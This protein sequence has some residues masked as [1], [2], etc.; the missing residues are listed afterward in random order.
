MAL[1]LNLNPDADVEAASAAFAETGACALEHVLATPAARR[2][3]K[4]AQAWPR[5]NRVTVVDGVHRDF[6]AAQ[7]DVLDPARRA[8]FEALVKKGGQD[9]F[10][11]LFDNVA[12][13]DSGRAGRLEDPVFRAAFDLVR[14]EAFLNL[15]RALTGVEAIRFADCQL[16][17]YMPGHFLTRHNDGIEGK[18]RVAAFVLNLTPDWSVDFGGV[19]NLL[20]D[21]G[22]VRLGFT[23]AFNRLTLFK[24][25]QPHSVSVVAPFAPAPRYA[26]TGWFRHGDEPDQ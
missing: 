1:P 18:N 20:D 13:Y 21:N 4:A 15:G 25:P 3:L 2:L 6:D 7:M 17:R 26:V 9:G 23:P 16:T 10:Q 22:D 24:V 11:Y 5:W 8:G 14:S 19:L 12:L